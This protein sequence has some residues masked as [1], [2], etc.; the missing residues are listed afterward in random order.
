VMLHFQK[1][2]LESTGAIIAGTVLAV[3]ALRTRS[4]FA[5]IAIHTAVA[6]TMDFLAL[7]N[8]GA[9]QKL[10]GWVQP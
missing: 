2:W 8:K 10:L 6:W 5:G 4:I 9:L 7:W 3:V 1:P